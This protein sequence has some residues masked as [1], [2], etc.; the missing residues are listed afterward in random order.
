MSVIA[1]TAVNLRARELAPGFIVSLIAAAAASFLSEHYD[2]PVM[3]FALLLGMALNFLAADGR[4][5]AGI[6]F[7]ARTVLRLGVALLGMRITLS[8]I[9]S[10]GW[11]PVALVVI[12]VVV[13]ILV[14]VVA[15]RA[16]GFQRLFG[17]LTGGATAICGASAA[18]ALA[19]AL[20]QHPQKERATL[21]TVIG[22]SALSTLAM[23]VYPM[24]AGW[25]QLSPQQAGVFLGATIHDVAQVVGAGYSMS[26]ETG[27]VATVVKLMR[28]AMLLPVIVCA[29][30]ITRRAGGDASGQRPPLLPW[31]AVGFVLLA[32]I[33]STGWVS[34]AVQGG[35][36][37]LSRWCLVVA[38]SA[39][40]MKTQLKELAA[41][42][43]KPIA[44]MVGETVFLVLLV[45]ALMH[46]GL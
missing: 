35:V 28:V 17:M 33:N 32:C 1:I 24:I 6:E 40:G 7:T 46:W 22:V 43:L 3:L 8:Q 44:L 2:A 42:G 12:L 18:L 5:K 38:I 9:A 13:T 41:V 30:M 15:A 19:A 4:C 10:L 25:L 29:A 34:A 20:P 31:F 36:N 16:L 21:F 14:S 37:D 27:D 11:K 39:L 45:L 23:I 26:T